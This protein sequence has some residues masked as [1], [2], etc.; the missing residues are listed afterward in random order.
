MVC[1]ILASTRPYFEKRLA[2]TLLG[3]T[4]VTNGHLDEDGSSDEEIVVSDKLTPRRSPRIKPAPKELTPEPVVEPPV[5]IEEP[6]TEES[7]TNEAEEMTSLRQR[8]TL[9]TG[10]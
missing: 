1:N 4:P 8:T 9:T 5:E 6:D 2:Y 10:M 7:E 3:G